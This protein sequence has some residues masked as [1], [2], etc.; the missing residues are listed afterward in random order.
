MIKFLLKKWGVLPEAPAG[1]VK[2]NSQAYFFLR[3]EAA[4]LLLLGLAVYFL[5]L[6]LT[7][8]RIGLFLMLVL[9][10]DLSLLAYKFGPQKGGLFYNLFHFYP[11]P[12]ILVLLALFL[13]LPLLLDLGLIWLIH[14][15]QDRARGLGLRY[16]ESFYGSHLHKL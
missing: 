6:K 14:I 5:F 2:P 1:A 13:D 9:L 3:A 11:L 7:W 16:P 4:F 12:S 8:F 15:A 10:P